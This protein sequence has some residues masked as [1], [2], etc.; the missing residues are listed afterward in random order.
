MLGQ[1][2][3]QVGLKF[4]Q[5]FVGIRFETEKFLIQRN[6]P[7]SPMT[8]ETILIYINTS[9]EACIMRLEELGFRQQIFISPRSSNAW[10]RSG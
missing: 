8:E 2:G 4:S 9:L 3:P 7:Q 10:V 1:I 6:I 5:D